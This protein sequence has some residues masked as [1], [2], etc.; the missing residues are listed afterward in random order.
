[1]EYLRSLLSTPGQRQ[2]MVDKALG[3]APDALILDLEDGVPPAMKDAA[4]GIVAEAV[5]SPRNTGAARF[6]RINPREAGSQEADLQAVAHA[7][8]DGIVLP[9]VEHV[10]EVRA[11]DDLL[12]R[13]EAERKLPAGEIKLVISIESARGVRN[14]NDLA[15]ASERTVALF[16]GGEDLSRDLGLPVSRDGDE[17][18]YAR[19]AV[20]IAAASAGLLAID[21]VWT[22][23]HD[24]EGLRRDALRARALGF[25]GK[26]CIHPT[27]IDVVNELFGPTAEEVELA[28]KVVAA[29]EQAQASGL[30]VVMMGEQFVERPTVERAQR[31]LRIHDAIARGG[32]ARG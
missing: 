31:T 5:G 21:R 23:F 7:G 27:Q 4:R 10:D 24:L 14:A 3:L 20:V 17:L 30:G 1:V 2:N 29:F 18:L 12:S 32:P 16:I 25:A 9:K 6:V 15:D 13:I 22:N 28:R 26:W 8:L 19:S 11:I